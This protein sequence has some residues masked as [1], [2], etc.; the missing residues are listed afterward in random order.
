[1][2]ITSWNVNSLNVRLPHVLQYL[3][4]TAPDILG[5]QELKQT[6]AAIDR[7]ALAAAGYHLE[8][9][10]QK[11]TTASPCS[12]AKRS[13]TW[14]AAYRVMPTNRRALSRQTSATCAC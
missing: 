2:N 8:S 6:D 14:C 7:T 10:G 9:H 12:R 4:E 13:P 1:M 3:Q 5:L 11:P